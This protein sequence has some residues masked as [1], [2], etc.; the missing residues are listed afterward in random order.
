MNARRRGLWFPDL[1][2]F[3]FFLHFYSFVQYCF[4]RCHLTLVGELEQ[5]GVV[6]VGLDSCKRRTEEILRMAIDEQV[7][8]SP[9][10]GRH[11]LQGG[12][13]HG[14]GRLRSNQLDIRRRPQDLAPGGTL[15][16]ALVSTNAGRTPLRNKYRPTTLVVPATVS[17]SR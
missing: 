10:L 5:R 9:F 12:Q 3:L 2:M 16:N 1:R 7:R 17:V 14:D 4:S 13:R 6:L 8:H 11:R 15:G